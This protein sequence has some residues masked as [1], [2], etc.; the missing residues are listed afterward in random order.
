MGWALKN[1][2]DRPPFSLTTRKPDPSVWLPVTYMKDLAA[3]VVCAPTSP[4]HSFFLLFYLDLFFAA[5]L[6][7]KCTLSC[8]FEWIFVSKLLSYVL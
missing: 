2:F 6:N 3:S 4:A 1:G 5:P 8:C 7:L